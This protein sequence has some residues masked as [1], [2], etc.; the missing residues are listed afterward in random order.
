V[1][2]GAADAAIVDANV[3]VIAGGWRRLRNV[4]DGKSVIPAIV[5]GFQDDY[6]LPSPLG[7][8]MGRSVVEDGHKFHNQENSSHV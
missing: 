1:Q 3:D 4:V 6:S 8:A 5:G 7:W 2:I